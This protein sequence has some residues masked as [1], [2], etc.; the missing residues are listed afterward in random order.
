MFD[1]TGH[2]LRKRCE[3]PARE[4]E[5]PT[6][7]MRRTGLVA[8]GVLGAEVAFTQMAAAA[9]AVAEAATVTILSSNLADGATVGEWGLSALVEVDGLLFD[10]GR[11]PD[12]VIRNARALDVDLSCVA[13]VVLQPF[14]F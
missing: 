9:P 4:A 2:G 6:L 12:T 7:R 13:D 11:N 10:T 14:P 1:E 5:M 8:L 3:L